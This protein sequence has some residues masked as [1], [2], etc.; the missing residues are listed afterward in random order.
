AERRRHWE[1]LGNVNARNII[2]K[3]GNSILTFNDD[4]QGTGAV[5]L[6]GVMSGVQ[7]S[8][9]PL[10]KHRIL[11]FG[12]GAAGIGNADQIS[13]AMMLEG[14]SEAE[15]RRNFW[16][17]DYRGLLTNETE[18]L[19]PFQVPYVRDVAE[20]RAWEHAEDGRSTLLEV[21]RRVKPTIMIGTS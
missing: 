4:I 21:I 13:A 8:G 16:A 19:F 3:Y 20:C 7:L 10:S 9:I 14:L 17:Y 15:A 6:A 1:D 2:N 5:T 12:P 11:V 18:G